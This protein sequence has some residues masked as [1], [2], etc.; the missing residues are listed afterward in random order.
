MTVASIIRSKPA[1]GGNKL[2]GG[3]GKPPA[4]N[5]NPGSSSEKVQVILRASPPV[6]SAVWGGNREER[7]GGR[8]P[9]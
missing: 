4:E 7:W 8:G 9:I 5:S 2:K 1:R 6:K 3:R